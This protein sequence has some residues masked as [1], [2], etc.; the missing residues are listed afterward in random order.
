MHD[1]TLQTRAMGAATARIQDT[2]M[3][4]VR[5]APEP[6][7]DDRRFSVVSSR[8]AAQPQPAAGEPAAA[9]STLK[10]TAR[11][12]WS[13]ALAGQEVA[14]VEQYR[15]LAAVLMRAQV[16]HGVRV[17]MIASATPSEG[18]TMTTANLALTLA[19]SYRRRVLVIDADLRK[20]SL[21][22]V[23]NVGNV[24]GLTEYLDGFGNDP[25]ATIQ[26]NPQL[27]LLPA[28]RASS[29]PVGGLASSRLLRLLE[30]AAA[31]FDMVLVDTP[32][33]AQLPDARLLGD[34]VDAAVL[35]VASGQAPHTA[36]EHAIAEIGR[37]R[38]LGIVFNR[39]EGQQ[40][41]YYGYGYGQERS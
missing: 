8:R 36:I 7:R 34:L 4:P 38:L 28:G 19:R 21:H 40:A 22:R 17:V 18:K 37:E 29:D 3:P 12:N 39:A 13:P 16:E 25:V 11:A 41:R 26:I 31:E 15:R 32:P 6:A 1:R 35:V 27:T 20:P 23:F 5:P 10:P 24:R 2:E 14:A 9:L 33:V 30:Q